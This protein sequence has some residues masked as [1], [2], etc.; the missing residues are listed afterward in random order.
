MTKILLV[1]SSVTTTRFW[2]FSSPEPETVSRLIQLNSRQVSA[3][4]IGEV[5]EGAVETTA[6]QL[7]DYSYTLVYYVEVN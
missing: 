1:T 2:V 4:D 3:K 6:G 5:V 7:N